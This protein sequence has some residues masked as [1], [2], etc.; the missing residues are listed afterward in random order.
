MISLCLLC[1]QYIKKTF[2][3]SFSITE[4]PD[5][6]IVELIKQKQIIQWY[7]RNSW[8]SGCP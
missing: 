1:N 5:V 8:Q 3:S 2:N 4:R 7:K 6:D